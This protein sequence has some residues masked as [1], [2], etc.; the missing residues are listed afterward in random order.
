VLSCQVPWGRSGVNFCQRGVPAVLLCRCSYSQLAVGRLIYCVVVM[1]RH[2]DINCAVGCSSHSHCCL[3]V[4]SVYLHA[5][6]HPVTTS[7]L[8]YEAVAMPSTMCWHCLRRL[9]K[10]VT[11]CVDHTRLT[12][13]NKRALLENTPSQ[14]W[15][16][17]LRGW[18]LTRNDLD[19]LM[20]DVVS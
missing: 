9:F 4:H 7:M 11:S 12:V 15:A 1:L 14:H 17:V 10:A 8:L 2:A 13:V 5:C 19:V 18:W 16:C 6:Y 20:T 3:I